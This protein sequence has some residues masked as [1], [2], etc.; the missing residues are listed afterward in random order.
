MHLVRTTLALAAVALVAAAGCGSDATA[1]SEQGPPLVGTEWQLTSYRGPGGRTVAVN[2][3]ADATL[4]FDGQGR[5][6]ARACNYMGGDAA[7]YPGGDGAVG[8]GRVRFGPGVGSTAMACTGQAAT[9]EDEFV[10]TTA[11]EVAWTIADRTLTLTGHD[12]RQ[13]TYR[14]RPS[15]YPD[16]NAR[17]VLAGERAGGQYR[18]AAGRGDGGRYLTIETRTGAGS[19]WG[20]SSVVAPGPGDCLAD[21]VTFGGP[22]GGETL[23][24]AWATPGVARV[25]VRPV[26]GGPETPLTLHDVP[27]TD[28][29]V[30][31]VWARDLR[32]GVSAIGFYGA[33]GRV[34]AC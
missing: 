17:T 22:L 24:A 31:S 6:S 32:P 8:S 25:T 16:R 14:V 27:D 30:A 34:I 21:S 9:L 26:P 13:L 12:G 29:R 5:W 2:A 11:G 4:R 10:A 3:E 23:V 7:L 1:G 33:G 19:P 18:L 15:I 28:L 20:M